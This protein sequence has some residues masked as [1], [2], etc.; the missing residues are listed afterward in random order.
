MKF[1]EFHS[2]LLQ[3]SRESREFERILSI[4][5]KIREEIEDFVKMLCCGHEIVTKHYEI[6]SKSSISMIS[7]RILIEIDKILS[8]SR[9]SLEIWVKRDKDLRS[10]SKSRQLS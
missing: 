3:I 8:N 1:R 5:I 4:S 10:L 6:L 7:S 9:D 2:Y